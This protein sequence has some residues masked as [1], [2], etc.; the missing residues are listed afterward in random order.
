MESKWRERAAI[1]AAIVVLLLER[2]R[3]AAGRSFHLFQLTQKWLRLLLSI[4]LMRRKKKKN[5]ENVNPSLE[6]AVKAR[7]ADG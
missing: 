3:V 2:E 7:E 4:T 1:E 5:S 6:L